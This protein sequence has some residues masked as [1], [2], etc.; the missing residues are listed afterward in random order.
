MQD[1]IARMSA[2]EE[3]PIPSGETLVIEPGGYHLMLLNLQEALQADDSFPITLVFA[4][5]EEIALDVVVRAEG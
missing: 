2:L 5:G 4:S 3:M 1:G